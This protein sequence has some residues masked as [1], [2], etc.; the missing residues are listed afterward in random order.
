MPNAYFYPPSYNYC[1]NIIRVFT[2]SYANSHVEIILHTTVYVVW[3]DDL[4]GYRCNALWLR[5]RNKSS[6]DGFVSYTG[7]KASMMCTSNYK[8]PVRRG[9]SQMLSQD[10]TFTLSLIM[11]V[12]RVGLFHMGHVKFLH[13]YVP[14]APSC[15]YGFSDTVINLNSICL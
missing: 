8:V 6:R 14:T 1:L 4:D 7:F 10:Q 2:T 15:L 12:Q 11:M 13:E 5:L 3:N 9:G